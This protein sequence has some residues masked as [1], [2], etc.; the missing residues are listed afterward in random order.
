MVTRRVDR[1]A[2]LRQKV[3][4]VLCAVLIA[5]GALAW[6]GIVR[7]WRLTNEFFEL[8]AT[9]DQAGLR[10]RFV[11]DRRSAVS[12]EVIAN[13]RAALRGQSGWSFAR[14]SSSFGTTRGGREVA[15]QR[16]YV[17]YAGSSEERHFGLSFTKQDGVWYFDSLWLGARETPR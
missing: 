15:S 17:H 13:W 3:G 16:G 2:A 14:K 6:G 11:P 5:L 1:Q 7:P 12:D 4:L 10:A 9:S 8:V